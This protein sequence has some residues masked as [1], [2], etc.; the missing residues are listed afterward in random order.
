MKKVLMSVATAGALFAQNLSFMPYGAYIN[1]S[2]SI[3][4]DAYILGLYGSDK[5]DRLL[6]EGG[7]EYMHIDYKPS[8]AQDYYKQSTLTMMGT[9][10]YQN[11]WAFKG[12]VVNIW[13]KT[14]QSSTN[15]D[16]VFKLAAQYYEYLKYNIEG[17]LYYS[18]YD[19]FDVYQG[20]LKAGQNFLIEEFANNS[21]YIEAGI[22]Q[23]RISKKGY[24]PKQNYTNFD[25]RFDI[26]DPAWM[27]SFKASMGKSAYKVA[28]D[29]W[30][31]YNL[32]EEYKYSVGV[33]WTYYIDRS[34]SLKV[35]YTRSKFNENT[36][37]DSN[38]DVF[39]LSF[40]R[41]F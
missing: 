9:Y 21:F 1:Y 30:I 6:L 26:Y 4:D 3:R 34:S 28:N 16:N 18:N 32:G 10:Y 20:T 22:N 12:G 11:N 37:K 2:D 29:G 7:L 31:V 36:P 15:Y 27:A 38:A 19:N 25:L 35:G 40:A 13:S 39:L 5:V 23:I 33:Q 41:A 14:D 8:A 17:A 24:A